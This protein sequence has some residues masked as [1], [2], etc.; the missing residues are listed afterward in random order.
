MYQM[1]KILCRKVLMGMLVTA[2]SL[3]MGM[4]GNLKGTIC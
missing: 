3:E 1:K 4:T 2:I